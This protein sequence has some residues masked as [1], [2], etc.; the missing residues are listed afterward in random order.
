[1]ETDSLSSTERM[2]QPVYGP[3]LPT[4]T[5]VL[6]RTGMRAA[7]ESIRAFPGPL[8]PVYILVN[9]AWQSHLP[10]STGKRGYFAFELKVLPDE[11]TADGPRTQEETEGRTNAPPTP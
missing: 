10:Y 6:V 7:I 2:R 8:G 1:M 3:P 9:N 4:G 11:R 5:A